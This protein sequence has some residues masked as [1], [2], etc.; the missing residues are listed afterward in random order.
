[1]A[2]QATDSPRRP[3]GKIRDFIRKN[4]TL[5]VIAGVGGVYFLFKELHKGS[6]GSSESVEG[7]SLPGGAGER[8]SVGTP[9]GSEEEYS[10]EGVD[11]ELGRIQEEI[12]HIN[13]KD[14]N[15]EFEK[16]NGGEVV[17]NEPPSNVTE[18]NTI[19]ENTSPENQPTTQTSAGGAPTISIHGKTFDG[20]T[21]SRIAKTGKT[22]S[23]SYI[24]Y[25]INFP[26]RQERW[27]YFTASGNWRQESNTAAGPVQAGGKS[28]GG[29]NSGAHHPSSGGSSPSGGTTNPTA[30]GG[31]KNH[32]KQKPGK[33]KHPKSGISENHP[34]SAPVRRPPTPPHATNPVRPTPSHPSGGNGNGKKKKR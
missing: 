31:G 3:S 5:S 22:G 28:G 14:E 4:K 20:A 33:S 13:E 32:S 18:N 10:H 27:Q 15:H 7:E 17:V 12:D 34:V 21:G 30:V 25:V 9:M 11:S 2:D 26:G 23:K 8:V 16:E 24:E 29:K 1:M 6:N 19:T